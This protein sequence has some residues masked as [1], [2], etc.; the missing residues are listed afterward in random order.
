MGLGEAP[1]VTVL[2]SLEVVVWQALLDDWGL[3]L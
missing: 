3:Y 1:W 2:I